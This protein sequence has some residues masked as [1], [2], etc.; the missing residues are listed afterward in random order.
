MHRSDSEESASPAEAGPAQH[1]REGLGA[2]GLALITVSD[3]RSLAD[4]RS[5]A[6][7]I[8]LLEA[9]G[10][11]VL[12]RSLVAD[13]PARIE[14]A[15]LAALAVPDC[16]AVLL[17]GGTGVSPRDGTPEVLARLWER[18]LPGFG[19]LFR[20]LSWQEIG[21]A[22]MLS[23]ACA[24]QRE[25]RLLVSLPGSPAAVRLALEGL[26]L[27]ELGHLVA[28]LQKAEGPQTEGPAPR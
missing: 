11:R 4:D 10:H 25:G 22:A 5:G 19:E 1:R 17:T 12:S 2:L 27:P 16:A 9:A 23:R 13:E 28:Q 24:G 7:T 8:S 15:I 3:T 6:L 14:A 20:W 18:E 21:P 26:L